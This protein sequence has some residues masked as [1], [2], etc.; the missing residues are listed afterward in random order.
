MSE[1]SEE[2]F[3]QTM[4]NSTKCGFGE[5]NSWKKLWMSDQYKV[6]GSPDNIVG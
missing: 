2:K 4:D 6:V 1:R 3:L 5:Y